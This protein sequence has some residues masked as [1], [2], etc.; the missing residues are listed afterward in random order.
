[1]PF[2]DSWEESRAHCT[3]RIANPEPDRNAHCGR[4][5]LPIAV[6]HLVWKLPFHVVTPKGVLRPAL[7]NARA[8]HE[9]PWVNPEGRLPRQKLM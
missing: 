3:M 8:T 4:R 5:R 6:A 9:R 2:V 1:M 7:C